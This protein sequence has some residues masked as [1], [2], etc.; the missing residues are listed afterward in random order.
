MMMKI[1]I[2]ILMKILSKLK[3]RK[4]IK[5]IKKEVMM[6]A[7]VKIGMMKVLK[8]MYQKYLCLIWKE[9]EKS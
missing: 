3:I 8:D 9:E 6:V 5:K 2:Q 7:I 1:I 4:K